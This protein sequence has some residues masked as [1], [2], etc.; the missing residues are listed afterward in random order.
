VQGA[1]CSNN[2]ATFFRDWFNNF[3]SVPL[4][5]CNSAKSAKYLFF[6]W[7]KKKKKKKKKNKKR[8]RKKGRKSDT[9]D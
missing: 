6:F 9:T 3:K 4:D 5:M 2:P 1:F 7:K 8:E